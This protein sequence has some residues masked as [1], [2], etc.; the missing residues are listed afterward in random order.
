[1]RCISVVLAAFFVIFHP[2]AFAQPPVVHTGPQQK[3]AEQV[4]LYGDPLPPGAIARLGTVR[5]RHIV[6]DGSGASGVAFSPDGKTLVSCGDVGVRVWDVA[7]G[8][9]LNWFSDKSP[10]TGACYSKDGKK[11]VT[12]DNKGSIRHWEV[13]TG[14]LLFQSIQPQDLQFHGYGAFISANG[15]LVG[16]QNL[17]G[18]Q[19][20]VWAVDTGARIL[21][22]KQIGGS[23][24]NSS[25]LS[26]DGKILLVGSGSFAQLIDIA[27]D[28]EIC[29]IK[30]PNA[31]DPT[32][33][34]FRTDS[35]FWF[36]FSPDG[37]VVAAIGNSSLITWEAKTGK[38][39][40]QVKE[41]LHGRLAFSPDGK[42]LACGG[43]GAIRLFDA[44][45]GKK[46]REFQPH[47][48]FVH[49]FA[50]SRDGRLLASVQDYVLNIWDV[51]SGK[52]LQAFPGHESPVS[53]MAFSPDGARLCTGDGEDGQLIEWDIL[54][55]KPRWS[56]G[57]HFPGVGSIAYSPD[58]KVIASGDGYHGSGGLDAQL[59]LWSAAD[60]KLVKEWPGH[61]NGVQSLAFFPDGRTLASSGSDARARLWDTST[62]KRVRQ[63]RGVAS[64]HRTL[65]LAGDGKTLLLAGSLSELDL[66]D[67]A[68][69]KRIRDL[70]PIDSKTGGSYGEIL[71]GNR[72]VLSISRRGTGKNEKVSFWAVESG[73]LLRSYQVDVGGLYLGAYAL[74][75]D[76]KTLATYGANFQPW[77]IHAIQLWDTDTGKVVGRLPGHADGGILSL[78]LSPD[79]KT[80]ASGGR[81][82]TV[83]LW[84]V[85]R[86]RFLHLWEELGSG[87][88]G[89]AKAA[90][91]M[92]ANPM[93]AVPFLRDRLRRA[94]DAESRAK[95][96]IA[97]LGSDQF[98]V[99]EKATR[100]L[101][102]LGAD[103]APALQLALF[104]QSLSLE[105]RRRI[106]D[107]LSKLKKSGTALPDSE[108]RSILLSV[109]ILE[110]I[111]NADAVQLL[112]ELA[113]GPA[114]ATVAQ[115]ARAA[116]E[117]LKKSSANQ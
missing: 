104:K 52:P 45:T 3:Q 17:S 30:S 99:R 18:G 103:A 101:Q 55:R 46:V 14:K 12:V 8:K 58:G 114:D 5:L 25:A 111:N 42:L 62:G 67:T 2:A 27:K 95:G 32:R 109:S 65:S 36:T 75:R 89:T 117:R 88:D 22:R 34:G 107:L 112:R 76:G 81:D 33:Q 23:F 13:G 72:T 38:L 11:L 6:R 57:G 54:S 9:R 77:H 31:R 20:R 29:V 105:A 94:V 71:P 83:L 26:P 68:S 64:P 116:L 74:S 60:G 97:L 40:Y 50:F 84:N 28:K 79:G 48:G 24:S 19:V 16:V 80:L 10:A 110:E 51:A 37:E 102:K 115:Q 82:A 59:R 7:T 108:P 69:G 35:I 93:Q 1:M 47:A 49:A 98:Q 61:L 43:K 106:E 4:D 78:A 70:M 66:W 113:K 86:A 53:S 85:A 56:C 87:K 92:A 63:I 100:E 90:K 15:E 73:R 44:A 96:H 39:R 91:K 41:T 21:E